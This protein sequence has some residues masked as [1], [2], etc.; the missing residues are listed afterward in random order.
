MFFKEQIPAK[1][2]DIKIWIAFE[3]LT[4]NGVI[5]AN[6]K[7]ISERILL[8]KVVEQATLKGMLRRNSPMVSNKTF[9]SPFMVVY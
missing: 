2:S 9:M 6:Y 3:K 1:V 8:P 7:V 5:K 4:K